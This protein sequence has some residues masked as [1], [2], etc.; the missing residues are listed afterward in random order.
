M[1]EITEL[2]EESG[3]IKHGK[4]KLSDGSLTDYYIDKYSFETTP[5]I[6]SAVGDALTANISA[7]TTDIVAG[8][9]LGAV[10]LVTAVSLQTGIP[11][12]YIRMGETYRG[13]QARVE[14]SIGKGQ[15]VTIL[16][17]VTTT[18]GT[19]L[20]SA[21]IIEELGGTVEQLLVVVDRNEGAVA[22]VK[23]AGYELKYLV[24]VGESFEIT[25]N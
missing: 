12:A 2:I 8:P 9:A 6:L 23:S 1:A 22:N 18:G 11:S 7:E 5:E 10:P 25:N 16:E 3:A 4:F 20:E 14:G 24:Q 19:I 15:R 13:T 21:E 17:D